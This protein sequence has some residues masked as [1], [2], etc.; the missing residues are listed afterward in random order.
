MEILK[1]HCAELSFHD[2]NIIRFK[3]LD[4]IDIEKQD[5]EEAIEAINTITQGK[6]HYLLTE[7]GNNF[8]ASA[9]SREYMASNIGSTSIVANA[10]YLKSLPIRLI[11]N[12]YVKINKPVVP[13]KVF[14]SEALALEWL[15]EQIS[16]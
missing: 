10:I 4:D 16:K 14:N 6:K 3:L 15:N 9:E 7:T 13:T 8:T 5:A 1:I 11:I 12:V 2:R